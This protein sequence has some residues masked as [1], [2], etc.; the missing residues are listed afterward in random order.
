MTD[1]IGK[2]EC[3]NKSDKRK[4]DKAISDDIDE[5]DL[6]IKLVGYERK[7]LE[8]F[9]AKPNRLISIHDENKSTLK[10]LLVRVRNTP[11]CK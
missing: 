2:C 10:N 6:R 1:T 7:E 4:I 8:E 11:D 9:G 3:I 5:L